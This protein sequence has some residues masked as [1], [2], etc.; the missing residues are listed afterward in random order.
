MINIKNKIDCCGC[1]ACEQSCPKNCI[2]MAADSEGFLY[3]QVDETLCVNCGLCQKACPILKKQM[4][5]GETVAAYAAYTPDEEI[6]KVSSSGGIFSV[7]AREILNRGGVIAGAAFDEDLSVRHILVETDR[8]LD[9]L[10]GSKYV[11][12][13]MEDTY[14]QIR[15]LLK[16][17][18]TVLF[19]GVSCQVAG[20]K[21]FLG[22]DYDNL[23]TVDVLCH[24]VPSPKVWAKYCREKES[25]Y[26]EMPGVVSFRDKRM[27]WRKYSISMKFGKRVEYCRRGDEDA[28]L[29]V[30]LK[31]LCLR[32]SCHSC[33]FKAFPRLSDLTIGDAWGI[34]KQI[35][36][37]DDDR[38]T[39]VVLLNSPKGKGLWDAVA[40]NL[41]FR[42]GELDTLLPKDADSRRSVKPH[43][44]RSRFFA[45]LDRGDSLEHLS[46][47]TRKSP[48]RRLLSYGKRTLKRLL[49]K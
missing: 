42:P 13:R 18:R 6:R 3:P 29:Q 1:G 34:E 20:L 24:G 33:R 15:D 19:T 46:K 25:I 14:I 41:V 7:L 36:E 32:P 45:A 8:E 27:G 31:D 26:G 21:T 10:R 12:S 4:P 17:G 49:R 43:A 37:L 5:S 2:T 44:N 40:E 48:Y 28:Y 47:L 39:S 23:Y 35:P 30:F 16:Q 22:R 9:R 11:Q 38:G